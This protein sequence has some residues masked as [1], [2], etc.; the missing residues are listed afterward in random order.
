MQGYACDTS[1]C[2]VTRVFHLR[3]NFLVFRIFSNR[4]CQKVWM[5]PLLVKGMPGIIMRL[6]YHWIPK[7]Q[8]ARPLLLPSQRPCDF[9]RLILAL[10]ALLN[11]ASVLNKVCTE[12]S[13]VS[14]IVVLLQ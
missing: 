3:E 14:S 6:E 9:R 2:F 10:E 7:G 4:V 13:C 5:F 1:S 12:E 11:S 8:S